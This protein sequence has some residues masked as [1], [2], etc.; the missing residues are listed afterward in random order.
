MGSLKNKLYEICSDVASEYPGWDFSSGEFKNKSLKHSTLAINLGFGFA[1]NNTPLQPAIFI[2]HKRSMA[3]FKKLNGYDQPTS[4]VRFQSVPHLLKHMPENLRRICWILADKN[5]QMN[6]APPS[7]G[8]QKAM[9]DI[10]ESRPILRAVVADGIALI[11]K[12]YHLDSEESFLRNLPPKYTPGSDKVPYDEFERS[13][14][15]MVCIAR[16]LT[17][18]FDFTYNYRDDS[19]STVFPKR[20]KEIDS[21]LEIIP[22]LKI[23]YD[24]A[25]N[26]A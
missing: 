22:E 6:V 26:I 10:T 25:N 19:Y 2:Y 13:K 24:K 15:V 17:G 16:A 7:E 3:L 18:D 8:A 11:E 5:L 4:I 9:I 14:G 12:L 23:Q 20:I 1:L 21:L